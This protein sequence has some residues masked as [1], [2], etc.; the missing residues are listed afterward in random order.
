MAILF[1]APLKV[2]SLAKTEKIFLLPKWNNWIEQS[3]F[4]KRAFPGLL[5]L[6]FRLFNTVDSNCSLQIFANDWIR[7]ADLWSQ[8]LP[9]Y[10]LSHNHC[11]TEYFLLRKQKRRKRESEKV[12][13]YAQVK[14]VLYCFLTIWVF[15]SVESKYVHCK[16]LPMT[17]FEPW[18]SGIGSERSANWATTTAL[19]LKRL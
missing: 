3:A 9:L 7:T 10:Q 16:I 17:G 4:L 6:Y 14:F 13:D 1:G 19:V 15:S 12:I 5:F 2:R 11:P 8:K 18:A